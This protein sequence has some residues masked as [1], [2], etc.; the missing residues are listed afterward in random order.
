MA[1]REHFDSESGIISAQVEFSLSLKRG[2]HVRNG[3]YPE[4]DEPHRL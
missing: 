2:T 4:L 1:G 3:V